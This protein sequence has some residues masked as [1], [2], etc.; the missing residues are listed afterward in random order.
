M[1]SDFD[2]SSSGFGLSVA[3]RSSSFLEALSAT[4]PV[5]TVPPTKRAVTPHAT[6]A[7]LRFAGSTGAG[8]D[9][10]GC[11]SSVTFAESEPAT[12][13]D[14][15]AVANPGL[16]AEILRRPMLTTIGA[17]SGVFPTHPVAARPAQIGVSS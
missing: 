6:R 13:M 3:L 17:G 5:A 11:R 16:L 15:D 7:R 4:T 2:F 12:V 8:P 10:M 1:V 9:E 14:D